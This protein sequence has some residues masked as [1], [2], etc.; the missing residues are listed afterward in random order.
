MPSQTG[1][2]A[3]R[4]W[5]PLSVAMVMVSQ[6]RSQ[7]RSLEVGHLLESL[8]NSPA[9]KENSDIT[10]T[11]FTQPLLAIL[12]ASQLANKVLAGIPLTLPNSG[13]PK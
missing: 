3:V 6:A 11:P 12:M 9:Q 4:M 2:H 13:H 5:A 1:M 8:S 7:D 10:T